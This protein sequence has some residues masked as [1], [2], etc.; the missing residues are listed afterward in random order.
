MNSDGV[1][2]NSRGYQVI[3]TVF[4]DAIITAYNSS[5]KKVTPNPLIPTDP[6]AES[7]EESSQ[8][9]ANAGVLGIGPVGLALIGIGVAIIAAVIVLQCVLK[10][11]KKN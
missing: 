11:N 9:D 7:S 3:G 4:T 2:F 8:S 5:G 10:K 6:Y 1:H